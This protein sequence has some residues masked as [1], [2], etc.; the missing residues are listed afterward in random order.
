MT[1]AIDLSRDDGVLKN[2][3]RHAKPDAAAPTQNL[4]LLKWVL[5]FAIAEAKYECKLR[6]ACV[7][8]IPQSS[9][10]NPT[11]THSKACV[12]EIPHLI[13]H[14]RPADFSSKVRFFAA[15]VQFQTNTKK[16]EQSMSGSR[17]NEKITAEFVRLVLN[18]VVNVKTQVV[19]GDPKE[20]IGKAVQNL[21]ADLLIMGSRAFGLIKGCFWEV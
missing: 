2:I 10:I 3:V 1:D 18:E 11:A 6:K 19:V 8:E 15:H 17:L 16:E 14:G 13:L 12:S 4:P 9:L 7:S 5:R 21:H 20:K